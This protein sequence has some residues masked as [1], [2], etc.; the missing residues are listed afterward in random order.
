MV[1]FVART[2]EGRTLSD[3]E[4]FDSL[5][6]A[7]EARKAEREHRRPLT[8]AQVAFSYALAWLLGAAVLIGLVCGILALTKLLFTLVK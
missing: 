5:A 7:L 3:E 6:A 8:P 4:F 1:D 2:D